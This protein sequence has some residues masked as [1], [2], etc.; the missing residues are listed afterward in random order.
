MRSAA[1]MLGLFFLVVLSL[2]ALNPLADRVTDARSDAASDALSCSTGVGE[3]SCAL[4]LASPHLF[5]TM[6]G[7]TVTETA[8]GS[9]DRTDDASIGGNQ[10]EVVVEELTA[11]T[12]YD[13]TVAY[14]TPKAEMNANP[15]L[16]S[17]L[18]RSPQ[19][20]LLMAFM[21]GGIGFVLVAI[22]G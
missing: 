10:S 14:L 18:E 11:S 17:I 13:F 2:G 19:L 22:R 20:A 9:G 12:S 4:T 6:T 1:S 3:T 5:D 15:G 7:V 21:F 8:P 16:D